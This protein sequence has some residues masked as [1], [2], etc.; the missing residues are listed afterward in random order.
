MG[1]VV[2]GCRPNVT[3]SLLAQ[4]TILFYRED[5]NTDLREWT[6]YFLHGFALLI[7]RCNIV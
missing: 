7:T 6:L 5:Y 3:Y 2:R 4:C 1:V